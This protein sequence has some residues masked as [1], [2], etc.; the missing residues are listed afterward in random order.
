LAVAA[1]PLTTAPDSLLK[2]THSLSESVLDNISMQRGRHTWKAGIEVRRV[3]IST[4]YSW[5]GT[6]SYASMNDFAANKVDSVVVAGYNPA[7]T[8]PKTE[9]FGY[10]QDEWKIRPNFTVNLGLRYEFYN[11][12]TERYKRILGFNIQDCGGYCPYG[13][14]NGTP[15]FYNFA[16]RL[17]LAW[18]PD[19]WHGN[20]VIRVGGGIYYG[21]GQIGVQLQ[22]IS[23]NGGNR[24]NLSA[25]TTPGLAYPVDL[26]PN[27]AL[28]TA[29]YET[30]RFRKSE[31]YQQWSAQIQQLLPWGFTSQV[32]YIGMENYHLGMQN[33]QDNLVNPA[34][35]KRT[36]PNFDQVSYSAD[37]GVASFHGLMAGLHRTSKSGL[38]LGANYTF[39]HAINDSD[40]AAENAAC[41]SC[42]K[43]NAAFDVRHNFYV[44]TSYP[45]PLG[46]SMLLRDWAISGVGSIRSG[47]PLT[48]TVSRKVTDL[49]DGNNVAQRPNVVPGVSLIPQG[50]QTV[51]HWINP[52]AFSIPAVGTWGNAGAGIVEGPG[53][54]Q[55]D[56]ALSR[57]IK[58]TERT[59]VSLRMEG[60]NVFNHPQLGNPNLNFSSLAAFGRITSV[61]NS[62]PV[63]TGTARSFQLAAR[64]TF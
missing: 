48:V 18:S 2:I 50:G 9:Y 35:G 10:V 45:L 37:W 12:L 39:S 16:P 22:G 54:F 4:Y 20:T 52:A 55:F 33:I 56:T 30:Q 11:E 60:F 13:E 8:M 14:L 40:T 17:S 46:H 53:L 28:G 57:T 7:R 26:N 61:S 64:F 5:D 49:P 36:L 6:I 32:G 38:F 31:T 44:Q 42:S 3:V 29:P 1:S 43:G 15:A 58:I 41:R 34:T 19:R 47:L 25:L 24:F 21:D 63:G 27:V 62:S 59:K 51:D 23:Y